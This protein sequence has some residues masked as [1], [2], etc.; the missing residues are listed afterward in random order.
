MT[1]FDQ[2]IARLLLEICRYTYAAAFDSDESAEEKSDA[3]NYI[4]QKGSLKK[5]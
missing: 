3:L 4:N 1:T 5:L 2:N